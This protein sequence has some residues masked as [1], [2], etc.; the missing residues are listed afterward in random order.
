MVPH[1]YTPT[2]IAS[3]ITGVFPVSFE[4]FLPL[5][6]GGSNFSPSIERYQEV[7]LVVKEKDTKILY[8]TNL[9]NEWRNRM[10]DG[11]WYSGT[12]CKN[13]KFV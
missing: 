9:K 12:K 2:P 10:I 8:S 4:K 6:Q 7:I 11:R 1:L 13:K 5:V 3:Q